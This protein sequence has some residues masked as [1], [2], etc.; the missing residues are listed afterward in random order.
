MSL[1]SGTILQSSYNFPDLDTFADRLLDR[2]FSNLGLSDASLWLDW[3]YSSLTGISY[4]GGC[5][6][7]MDKWLCIQCLTI[8]DVSFK[9]LLMVVSPCFS[10][11]KL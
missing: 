10:T 4:K 11:V 6:D 2:K 9:Y 1:L 7:N 8:G 3:V 5:S